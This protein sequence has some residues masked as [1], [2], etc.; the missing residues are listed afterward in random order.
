MVLLLSMA[1]CSKDEEAV[2]EEANYT[3]DL[4]LANETDWTVANEILL[5]V[6]KHRTAIGLD[7]LA[8]DRTMA[9][10][11]AVDHTF[12]MIDQDRISHDHFQDR[13]AALKN[14]GAKIVAENVAAGYENAEGVVNA[15]L[16]SPAHRSI[17]EGPYSHAGFGVLQDQRGRYYFTQL[18]YQK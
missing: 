11:L 15:W 3:V 5:L 1:S 17:I 12:Y 8:M 14:N 2:V 13:R 6:N 16:N 7:E 10:A 9:S 18:F 4:S